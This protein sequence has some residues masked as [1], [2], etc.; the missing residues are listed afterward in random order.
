M[1]TAARR[2]AQRSSAIRLRLLGAPRIELADGTTAALERLLAALLAMLAIN[3]PMPRARAAA[4]LW[5]EADDKGARNNLRQRLFRL[6]QSARCDLVLPDTTLALADGLTHDLAGLRAQLEADADAARGELLGTLSFDDCLELADWVGVA[7][8]Q[9]AVARRAALAEI[10]ARLESA[11]QIAAALLYAERLVADDPLAEHAH[12]RLMRLHY[13]RGDRAAAMASFGRCREVLKATLM[14]SPGKETLELAR[15]IEA[16]SAP[17]ATAARPKPVTALRPPRLIG[18]EREWQ[19][20]VQARAARRMVWLV[21]APGIGKTRLL[22]DFAASHEGTALFG[23]RPGDARVP[24]AFAARVIVALA[25]SFG[26][27]AADWARAELARLAPELGQAAEGKLGTLRLY[28]ALASALDQWRLAGLQSLA[29][30]DLQFAD[31]ASLEMLLWLQAQETGQVLHWLIAQREG[32]DVA[33]LDAWRAR[34]EPQ[35]IESITLGP[36]D[37]EAVEALLASLSIAGLDARVWAAPLARHTGGNP[38]YI[39]ETLLAL[40]A[41]GSAAFAGDEAKLPAPANIGQLIERRL[42]Q[43]S[44]AALRLARVAA[45]AGPEFSAE[46]AARVLGVHLL[47]IAEPWRELELA[48]VI[49]DQGF[50][51][52]LILETTVRTVPQPIAQALHRA[53]ATE[54]Q[55]ANA[56]P[57][58]IARHWLESREWLPA[59]EAFEAAAQSAHKASRRAEEADCWRQAADCRER[60]GER[61]AA[62][63]AR[64]NGV[65][66]T[67]LVKGVEPARR[68]AGQLRACASSSE[69]HA[70]ALIAD[71]KVSLMAADYEAGIGAARD[72]IE[73]ARALQAPWLQF[74]AARLLAVGLSQA[75]RLDQALQAIEPF[76]ELV[77]REG[78]LEQRG[79]FWADYAYVLNGARRLSQTAAALARAIDSAQA[80][81]DIAELAT[82]TS[83]LAIV[84][85]NLGRPAHGL[86]QAQRARALR[87]RLGELGGPAGGA[88]DMYVGMFC[89]L[90]G[91]YREALDALDAALGCFTRDGQVLWT[92]VAGNHRASLWIELGQF[93]RAQKALDYAPPNLGSVR[94]RG[95]VIGSR[96]QRALGR[97]G[98]AELRAA[99]AAL[100]PGDDPYTEMLTR[101]EAAHLL[102]P[103]DAARL[104]ADVR[105]QAEA[106]ECAGVA[107]KARLLRAHYLYKAGEIDAALTELTGLR[108]ERARIQ[109]A[110]LYLPAAN[111]I[112]FEILTAAA[113][114]AAARDELRQGAAWIRATALPNVPEEFRDSFLARNAVNRSL[115]TTHDRLLSR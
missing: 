108:T 29:L 112:A 84:E 23:A 88:I 37:I 32:D 103:L 39:L 82:L 62:F 106:R 24:F 113:E 60:A 107:L 115:L 43:L 86:E 7:R 61:Q 46:L 25:Q 110:D 77:E 50:A 9:W 73:L 12:R 34:A 13:L 100:G 92:A 93:A 101:L 71:A 5:P 89:T 109:P 44:A 22:G 54:L 31:D 78:S 51:H 83:N 72:A 74:E 65:E 97:S 95:W 6:R 81:G 33:A 114:P 30:D 14:A 8:E 28:R 19:A 94:S 48:Q 67:L 10:A 91:R 18:R 38:M 16:A 56:P 36:L 87:E 26:A 64:C 41:R 21:G 98:E 57:A 1:A 4:L 27:P 17:A 53:I 104:C 99:L 58:A 68:L 75:G 70:S 66:A 76:R 49:R 15:T 52:D 80:L 3:G 102:P 96:L 11:G 42:E 2:G 69:E 79:N 85:G 105:H 35:A 111:W 59:G 90:L 63:R 40:L 45:L 55:A 20:I 47:D